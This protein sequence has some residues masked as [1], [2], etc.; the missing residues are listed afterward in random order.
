MVI[1]PEFKKDNYSTDSTKE[2]T[3]FLTSLRASSR[4]T[5]A[6]TITQVFHLGALLPF[7][8]IHYS[9]L[10]SFFPIKEEE[11]VVAREGNRRGWINGTLI[12]LSNMGR[13]GYRSGSS[14][15]RL[16]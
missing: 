2:W 4:K 11:A 5:V 12:I 3:P 6:L 13:G 10:K 1:I 8:H 9:T 16:W 7:N 14:G 15:W